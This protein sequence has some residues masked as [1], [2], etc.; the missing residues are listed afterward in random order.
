MGHPKTSAGRGELKFR[1]T[2]FINN[3]NINIAFQIDVNV[4][5]CMYTDDAF[6]CSILP[7][8]VEIA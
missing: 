1:Y 5:K 7:Q 2:Y 3:L 6:L 8:Y 4:I